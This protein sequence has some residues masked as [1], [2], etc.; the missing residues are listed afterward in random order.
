MGAAFVAAAVERAAEAKPADRAAVA[1]LAALLVGKGLVTA[2]DLG[3]ALH[4]YLEFLEDNLCDVP[5]LHDNLA[6]F[7]GPLVGQGSL[8]VA[9]LER[10][11]KHF[12]DNGDPPMQARTIADFFKALAAHLA[13]L[14]AAKGAAD[15]AA[16]Q[17]RFA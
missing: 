5:T 10:S 12:Q 15:A 13:S 2:T 7:L 9:S 1:E 8:A 14:G 4:E 16:A 17:S 6:Q 11:L 3:A